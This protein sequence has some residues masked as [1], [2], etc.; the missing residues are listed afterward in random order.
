MWA[1]LSRTARP[2]LIFDSLPVFPMNFNSFNETLVFLLS[3][4]AQTFVADA[5]TA[6][7]VN[8]TAAIHI[9]L[10]LPEAFNATFVAA[11]FAATRTPI[12]VRKKTLLFILACLIIH[13]CWDL[14]RAIDSFLNYYRDLS[15]ASSATYF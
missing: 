9:W 15:Y 8:F 14:K 12:R 13:N 5:L 1:N 3:P 4:V 2:H 7:L 6:I 10:P 11:G